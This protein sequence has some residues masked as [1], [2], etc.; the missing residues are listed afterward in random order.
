MPLAAAD[1]IQGDYRD[2][3]N[4]NPDG[5]ADAV[6]AI[7]QN[8]TNGIDEYTASNFAGAMQGNNG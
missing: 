1:P 2:P 8:N 4:P 7:W 5:P 3:L 6:I